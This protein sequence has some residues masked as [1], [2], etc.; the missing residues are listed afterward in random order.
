MKNKIIRDYNI[1]DIVNFKYNNHV[2]I[3]DYAGTIMCHITGE[4]F[5]VQL[6][7][8][9]Y[10]NEEYYASNFGLN[11]GDPNIFKRVIGGIGYRGKIDFFNLKKE[12]KTWKDMIY[13]C[14]NP[15]NNLFPY[16]GAL[17]VTV[18]PRWHCFEMFLYD[19]INI[20]GYEAF[21]NP[22]SKKY[23]ELDIESKQHQIPNNCK[24]YGPGV[25]SLKLFYSSD[26][27]INVKKY[28]EHLNQD[29]NIQRQFTPLVNGDYSI[30][31]YKFVVNNHPKFQRP[32]NDPLFNNTVYR[33]LHGVAY[34]GNPIIEPYTPKK[35]MCVKI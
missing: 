9:L 18:C 3:I 35:V 1:G 26:V 20:D 2:K 29:F 28:R 23:Y 10:N 33:T 32:N 22:N 25:V 15:N 34:K 31:D 13:R 11:S 5:E 21:A 17:G 12:Y 7:K 27:G 6:Y 24:Y 8:V 30:N 4:N 14:Y 19:L 16:Y